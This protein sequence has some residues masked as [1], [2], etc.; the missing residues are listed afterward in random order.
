MLSLGKDSAM[1]AGSTAE[2][3]V[4]PDAISVVGAQ[5]EDTIPA[6]IVVVEHLG[7]SSLLY[8]QIDGLDELITVEQRGK[9]GFTK[10]QAISLRFD[11][12]QAHL[13]DGDGTR[14]DSR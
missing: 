3:G 1:L 7:G 8:V 2:L 12:A 11:P 10:D 14:I 4:R 5:S 6:R 13:F 9:T